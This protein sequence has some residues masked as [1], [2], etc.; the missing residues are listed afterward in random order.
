MLACDCAL[1]GQKQLRAQRRTEKKEAEAAA[2]ERGKGRGRGRGR[3]K[4]CNNSEPVSAPPAAPAQENPA[5]ENEEE[6]AE[7]NGE[8]AAALKLDAEEKKM[9]IERELEEEKKPQNA[10]KRRRSG[11]VE[12]AKDCAG[13][14]F[15]KRCTLFQI[16]S[17][18]HACTG[19]GAHEWRNI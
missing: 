11:P 1:Q 4:A 17:C 18:M 19:S 7:E 9:K 3:G 2:R 15:C 6:A 5:Q 13:L 12:D 16:H 10:R 14:G 8:E